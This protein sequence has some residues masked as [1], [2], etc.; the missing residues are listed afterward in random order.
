MSSDSD[1]IEEHN[2]RSLM[3]YAEAWDK[4]LVID[5]RFFSDEKVAETIKLAVERLSELKEEGKYKGKVWIVDRTGKISEDVEEKIKALAAW[6]AGFLSWWSEE[7]F[8]RVYEED[9]KAKDGKGWSTDDHTWFYDMEVMEANYERKEGGISVTFEDYDAERVAEKRRQK[10]ESIESIMAYLAGDELPNLKTKYFGGELRMVEEAVRDFLKQK[11]ITLENVR[12]WDKEGTSGGSGEKVNVPEAFKSTSEGLAKLGMFGLT[13]PEK[14]GGSGL[15]HY[16]GYRMVQILSSLWPS[17]A[18]TI[19]VSGSAQDTI[20]KFGTDEQKEDILPKL[21]TGEIGAIAITEPDAGSDVMSMNTSANKE[22]SSY[23]L[24]GRKI[25][26][27]SAG[28][29]SVYLVFA[30]TD[31]G[32]GKDGKKKLSAFLVDKDTPGFSIGRIEKKPGQHSSPTGELTFEDCKIPEE[33]MLGK[34]GEGRLILGYMLAGG[35]IGIASLALGIARTAYD[36]AFKY[37]TEERKQFGKFIGDFAPVKERLDNMEFYIAASDLLIEYASYLK[38]KDP[39]A[40]DDMNVMN[41]VASMAKLYSSEKGHTVTLDALKTH[42]GYGYMV[43]YGLAQLVEDII[44]TMI[45]EGTSDIQ[46]VIIQ[47]NTPLFLKASAVLSPEMNIEGLM[48]SY[49]YVHEETAVFKEEI[50]DHIGDIYQ[51][52]GEAKKR[53]REKKNATHYDAALLTDLVVTRLMLFKCIFLH[54]QDNVSEEVK[55]KSLKHVRM[56]ARF[57]RDSLDTEKTF[58][59]PIDE[60]TLKGVNLLRNGA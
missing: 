39:D 28:I 47:K 12:E 53:L 38:D 11:D 43:E 6:N 26:I 49:L 9:V 5:A 40:R 27:T 13:T 19:A 16:Y 41:S 30:V 35:R 20:N 46:E 7:A 58:S 31:K 32:E 33:N 3:D 29:A 18:V 10:T 42:G 59:I 48:D 36:A 57:L 25:F 56:A 4:I 14:Y 55:D 50:E 34:P 21:A 45:Y 8:K 22:G 52:I 44:V 17:L 51:V 24:N 23:V 1:L 37:A 54:T 60:T 2:N 15:K